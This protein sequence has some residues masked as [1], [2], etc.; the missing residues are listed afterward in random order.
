M[1][2]FDNF[3]DDEHIILSHVV[4][5]DALANELTKFTNYS[6]QQLRDDVA[7]FAGKHIARI[8][9]REAR[10]LIKQHRI[11]MAKFRRSRK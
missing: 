10:E 6:A 2:N 1:A 11:T 4:A 8:S 5:V 3:T 7:L 9:D